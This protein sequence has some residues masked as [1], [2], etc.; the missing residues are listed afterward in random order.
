MSIKTEHNRI[1]DALDALYEELNVL[2]ASCKHPNV[3]VIPCS[4]TGNHDPMDDLY[5]N[6]N[7][8]PDCGKSWVE[9]L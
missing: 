3:E 4:N 2:R 5:W 1:R 7:Y 9:D 8:C 6:D